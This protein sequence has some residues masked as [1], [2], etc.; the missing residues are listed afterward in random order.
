[1]Q[2]L[3]LGVDYDPG[4]DELAVSN[5]ASSM[6]QP[7]STSAPS[8]SRTTMS[9]STKSNKSLSVIALVI[10]LVLG[11]LTG[12]GAFKLKTKASGLDSGQPLQ[13]VAG[14]V[15]AIKA[16]D[17]FGSADESAF[18]D[19]AEGYLQIGGFQGEGSHHLLR[20]G[21]DSQTVYLVSSVTDLDKFDGMQVKV[22]GETNKG[23]KVGWLMDVGRIQVINPHGTPPAGSTPA[24]TSQ[25]QDQ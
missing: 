18:K 4:Q 5:S 21:G 1:M 20:D 23:Q 2:K 9:S 10:A 19:S 12:W 8:N 14:D 15:N 16:G 11:S 22:W 17:V 3:D 25:Q 24:D 6:A 13:Q 7:M